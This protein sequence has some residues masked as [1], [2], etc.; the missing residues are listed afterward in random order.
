MYNN[1]NSKG[2]IPNVVI[3]LKIKTNKMS[4]SIVTGRVICRREGI[5]SQ[6]TKCHVYQICHGQ[7]TTYKRI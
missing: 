3:D 5:E 1:K 6:L 7:W 4:V 2:S